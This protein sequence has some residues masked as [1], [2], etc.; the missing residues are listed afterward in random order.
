MH[1]TIIDN[2]AIIEAKDTYPEI[3]RIS[4]HTAQVN[5]AIFTLYMNSNPTRVEIPFPPLKP[6]KQEK[7]CPTI[8]N[9]DTNN[10]KPLS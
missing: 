4:N 2:D 3:K 5:N 10:I 8:L 6:K 7:S 9:E 1:H